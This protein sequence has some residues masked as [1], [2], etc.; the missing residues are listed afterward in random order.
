MSHSCSELQLA[1]SN[2]KR[3][4][5]WSK[6]RRT[7]QAL[8]RSSACVHTL[9]PCPFAR[10]GIGTDLT[11]FTPS[12]GVPFILPRAKF[13][14]ICYPP[15]QYYSLCVLFLSTYRLHFVFTC[16]ASTQ[17]FSSLRDTKN[18]S[19]VLDH[20]TKHS[21]SFWFASRKLILGVIRIGSN[22]EATFV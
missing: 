3:T 15:P 7:G 10:S 17:N 4:I 14:P 22:F 13:T 9:P 18:V 8:H 11:E 1:W 20:R 19:G 16:T 2:W 6:G 12:L 21:F 5:D